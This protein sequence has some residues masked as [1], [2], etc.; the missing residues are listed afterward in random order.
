MTLP[1]TIYIC[2]KELSEK[3]TDYSNQ[4][5]VLNP[6]YEVKLYDNELC[7]KFLLEEFSQLHCD[8]FKFIVDGPIKSDF[9]RCC[10]LYKYGGVYV[11]ADIKPLLPLREVIDE[12]SQ[13][14]TCLS[15]YSG[16]NLHFIMANPG[17]PILDYLINKYVEYYT[18]EKEYDYWPW[19]ICRIFDIYTNETKILNNNEYNKEGIYYIND[20]KYQLLTDVFGD[21]YYDNH[22]AYNNKRIFYTRTDVWNSEGHHFW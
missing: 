21:H 15:Y 13:F 14:V 9:W 19:S 20:K 4:W 10:I 8:I 17:E 1:K 18:T 11:D 16:F 3:F 22:C 5:L 6:E 7:E 2:N 12:D